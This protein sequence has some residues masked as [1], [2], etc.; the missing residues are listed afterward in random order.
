MVIGV[1]DSDSMS[2]LSFL[3][4]ERKRRDHDNDDNAAAVLGVVV[5]S[6]RA[7]SV[8]V[9]WG[10]LGWYLKTGIVISSSFA[11]PAVIPGTSA[12]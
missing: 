11:A 5:V 3:N 7:E 8:V 9:V 1:Y 6:G 10:P 12:M 2:L 4:R